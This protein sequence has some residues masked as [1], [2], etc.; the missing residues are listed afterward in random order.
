LY[1]KSYSKYAGIFLYHAGGLI[2]TF[3]EIRD[4]PLEKG[5]GEWV[6]KKQQQ[7]QQIMQKERVFGL[8]A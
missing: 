8:L 5:R 1:S 2:I 7:Q 6:G 3:N 4:G